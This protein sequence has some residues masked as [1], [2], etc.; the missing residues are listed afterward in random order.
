MARI[1]GG[2]KVGHSATVSVP[3]TFQFSGPKIN[4]MTRKNCLLHRIKDGFTDELARKFFAMFKMCGSEDETRG[5]EILFY[6]L[7]S[8]CLDREDALVG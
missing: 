3:L 1:Y 8:L 5:W 6:A 2:N 4:R 7:G